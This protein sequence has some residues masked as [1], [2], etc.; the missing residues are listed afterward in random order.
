M[1]EFLRTVYSNIYGYLILILLGI[2]IL[3]ILIIS[4]LYLFCNARK[5]RFIN[6]KMIAICK[7]NFMVVK[8]NSASECYSENVE[9]LQ[10]LQNKLKGYQDEI[11]I[12]QKKSNYYFLMQSNIKKVYKT[13]S[14]II[15]L[16]MVLCAI[17]HAFVETGIITL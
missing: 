1:E 14:C 3:F 9:Y 6:K 10:E 15:E 17:I 13:V 7:Y 2:D 8:F 11:T 12:Y 16:G 4:I 5:N